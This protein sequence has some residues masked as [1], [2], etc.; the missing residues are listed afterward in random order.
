M[1]TKAVASPE[2]EGGG[3]TER[4]PKAQHSYGGFGGI[5][6]NNNNNNNNTLL[7]IELLNLQEQLSLPA[8]RNANRGGT[9]YS[10]F[11]Y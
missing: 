8:N 11:T 1:R 7:E 4:A 6:P 2:G 9:K 3:G 10:R 5:S